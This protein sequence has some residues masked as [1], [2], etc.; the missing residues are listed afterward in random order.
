MCLYNKCL[1]ITINPIS[2]KHKRQPLITKQSINDHASS[3]I[4]IIRNN[5]NSNELY[6]IVYL[7]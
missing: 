1:R 6:D 3:E 2:I 4:N 7:L 5:I